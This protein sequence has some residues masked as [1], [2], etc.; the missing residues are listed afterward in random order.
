MLN[1]NL[2]PETRLP[3]R[4]PSPRVLRRWRHVKGVH[5]A[6]ADSG[7]Q[8][9]PTS[10]FSFLCV[11]SLFLPYT[12]RASPHNRASYENWRL[13]NLFRTSSSGLQTNSVPVGVLDDPH[14]RHRQSVDRANALLNWPRCEW[15]GFFQ[16]PSCRHPEHSHI[17][18]VFLSCLGSKWPRVSP[19]RTSGP[20]DYDACTAPGT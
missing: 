12:S 9:Q 14:A 18:Y 1:Q 17:C 13:R 4:L 3:T 8:S 16:P 10:C 7:L 20:W 15:Q 5:R 2:L 11:G 6:Q 19:R